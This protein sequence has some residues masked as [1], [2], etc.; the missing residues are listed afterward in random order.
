MR[1]S[2]FGFRVVLCGFAAFVVLLAGV[3]SA[4]YAGA[5]AGVE[6]ASTRVTVRLSVAD[7]R[8]LPVLLPNVDCVIRPDA[9]IVIRNTPRAG[10]AALIVADYNQAASRYG[11]T[12]TAND[13]MFTSDERFA[14][15]GDEVRFDD[16]AGT[17]TVTQDGP[18]TAVDA[19]LNGALSC[20]RE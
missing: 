6:A 16:L 19:T 8:E 3:G 4:L 5:N 15:H 11:V 2:A 9:G 1:P 13:I 7:G 18:P 12:I 17:A 20:R 10:S 14:T